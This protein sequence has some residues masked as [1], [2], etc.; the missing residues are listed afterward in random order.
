MD[1]REQRTSLRRAYSASCM[2][3]RATKGEKMKLTLPS[4]VT[5]SEWSP[6]DSVIWYYTTDRWNTKT[7]AKKIKIPK[8]IN[9]LIETEKQ[10]SYNIGKAEVRKEVRDLL[11]RLNNI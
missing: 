7:K 3:F 6:S 9:R 8:W 2:E 10:D 1:E 4:K 5:D 11:T